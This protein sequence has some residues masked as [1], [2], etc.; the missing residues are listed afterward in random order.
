MEGGRRARG[1]ES[2]GGSLSPGGMID[3]V[4]SK[5]VGGAQPK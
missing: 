5:S 4:E 2:L 3:S 1:R